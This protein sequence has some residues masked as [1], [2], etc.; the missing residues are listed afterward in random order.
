MAYST[1]IP[2]Q[3][4][5]NHL[6]D[7]DWVIVDCRFDLADPGKGRRL[8]QQAHIPG[9]VYAH[10]DEDLSSPVV[11]GK[12]GRHPLPGLEAFAAVLSGWGIDDTVQVAVYDDAGGAYAARLWWMLRWLGHPAAAIL[13]GGF[14]VWQ[15]NGL[16][17]KSDIE[18]RKARKFLPKPNAALF[19][20]AQEILAAQKSGTKIILDARGPERYAGETEPIDPVAGHIPG[21]VNSPYTLNLNAQG[22]FLSPGEL[23]ARYAEI[24]GGTRPEDVIVYCGSGVTAAHNILA[25]M[26][27]GLGE[28]VLY[29]GSWSEYITDP[30]RPVHTGKNP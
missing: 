13:D 23:K 7:P 1:I 25:M 9:A 20:S 14:P 29:P 3:E 24:I 15:H 27:A 12:T 4:L 21:A 5:S 6:D 11:P 16:P 18:T 10:L 2:I 19:T 22:Q 8:Y 30:Q 17:T 28:A 26:H